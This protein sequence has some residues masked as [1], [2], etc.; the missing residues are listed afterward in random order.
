M[1]PEVTHSDLVH[2]LRRVDLDIAVGGLP[3]A[4]IVLECWNRV[5]PLAC[6][7]TEPGASSWK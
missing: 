1:W 6:Q 4:D 5:Q 3:A 2:Q 7:N